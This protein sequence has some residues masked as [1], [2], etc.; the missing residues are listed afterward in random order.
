MPDLL[1]A[2]SAKRLKEAGADAVKFMVYY[3][4]DEP[5]AIN[6]KTGLHRTDRR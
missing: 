4:V 6:E 2:W 1:P 3:D 5:M